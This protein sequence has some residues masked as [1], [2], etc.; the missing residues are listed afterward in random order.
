MPKFSDS[1]KFPDEED[2]TGKPEDT[3]DI[4]VEDDDVEIKVDVK[5]DTPSED[6]FVEPL[7]NNIK[8][9]LEKADDSE[10]YSHNVKLKF[11]QYKKAW[12][13]ERREKEAALR[14]Q[15]EALAVAQR[16]LDEN[17]KLKN[18][19]QS[20]EK[21]LISTYQSSAE[22]EVD[23]ASRNY[24]E[25]YDS[26]DSDKLLEAQQEMIRAQLKLDKAKNFRPTVQNEENDVQITPQRIQNPQMDP[27]VASWVSK[28]PW[29]VDQNKRSMRRYAEGVHEDLESRYGRGF[30]GTDEYYAAID[31][32]V[33]RRFPEE[34]VGSN[35]EEEEKPQRTKPSTVVAPAKRSTAP[36]KVVLSK[37]QVGLAKKLG[38][39]NEQYARELMK[40]EA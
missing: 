4:S 33:Q 17:R 6:R 32:E 9:D 23:K 27:K 2:N 31:K 14:E 34:F 3:L 16:I 25:A 1:Y 35:N 12:H 5:D 21:E 20:G 8:E 39:S 13:D 28:N 10:D 19:L 40:L 26:G 37:T 15:Q 24:K 11:K 38:L 29:F 22:M 18:V 7:P 36:K 30:I